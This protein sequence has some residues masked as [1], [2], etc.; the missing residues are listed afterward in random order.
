ML[1]AHDT[2]AIRNIRAVLPGGILENC[3]VIISD[4]KIKHITDGPAG[5][6][7]FNIDGQNGLLMPGMVDLHGDAL[8]AAIAPRPAAPFSVEHVLP[9]YD[10]TLAINGITTMYHCVAVAQLGGLTK[11][12]RYRE[13]AM[14]IIDAIHAYRPRAQVRTKIHLRY[15]I[16]DTGSLSMVEELIRD[17]RID[18]MSLMDHTPGYGV[19]PNVEAYRR[20]LERSGGTLSLADEVVSQRLKM[21]EKIDFQALKKLVALCHQHHIPVAS[22]DDHTAAKIDQAVQMGIKIAEFPVTMETVRAARKKG[23]KT[24][25]GAANLVRGVSHAGNLK[26][27]DMVLHQLAD[28]IVSDYAPMSL[29]Q[30]LF[31]ANQ[32]S[33]RPLHQLVP[34]FTRNPLRAVDEDSVTGEIVP[35]R[36]ADVI[37][38]HHHT[39]LP[40]V[41]ATFVGGTPVYLGSGLKYH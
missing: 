36:Q 7:L 24:V 14:E 19:F 3:A 1:R 13:K 15:E 41:I 5:P 8:E 34:L 6:A 40:R 31:K 25:F 28:I 16:L 38:L 29:L 27:S 17:R 18:L 35:G 32:L 39:R 37:L 2:I 11:P 12:L 26:A 23:M 21:R 20:Y 22:H 30:G 4:G 9:S 33:R 10:T